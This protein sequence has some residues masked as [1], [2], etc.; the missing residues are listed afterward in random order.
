MMKFTN[1]R[2]TRRGEKK[3]RTIVLTL[4]LFASAALSP[5]TAGAA[6]TSAAAT[7]LAAL[8]GEKV[9]EPAVTTPNIAEHSTAAGPVY[10]GASSSGLNQPT[11][12]RSGPSVLGQFTSDPPSS[13]CG[14]ERSPDV[15]ERTITAVRNVRTGPDLDCPV[16]DQQLTNVVFTSSTYVVRDGYRWTHNGHGWL[17]YA[18]SDGS[19]SI[20]AIPQT[21]TPTAFTSDPPSSQ[22]GRERSPDV[23]ERTITAVR[24]VRTGPDLDCPVVDQQLTNVVFTSS[25]YVVRD[26]YRWTHNGHGWLAY[27]DSDGSN[28]ILA[29][30]QTTTPTDFEPFYHNNST[31]P[32]STSAP[33]PGLPQRGELDLVPHTDGGNVTLRDG[34][35]VVHNRPDPNEELAELEFLREAADFNLGLEFLGCVFDPRISDAEGLL[36]YLRTSYQV[37]R[38]SPSRARGYVIPSSV[39]VPICF[40]KTFL[41]LPVPPGP[42]RE[43]RGCQP[44]QGIYQTCDDSVQRF[45][46]SPAGEGV[47]ESIN[48]PACIEECRYACIH[49]AVPNYKNLTIPGKQQI[50]D[51]YCTF[52]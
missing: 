1:N 20:L 4:L 2:A 33:R 13:Q 5:A 28:S 49:L 19:N 8:V 34:Y 6:E 10:V 3:S 24:N 17:A 31:I 41:A 46:Q 18:D 44:T 26:G 36:S 40:A 14:R 30:P 23:R 22:C 48:H 51:E 52:G 11:S 45:Y 43:V 35:I 42:T 32:E 21:T 25:T 12:F 38:E 27:A 50:F 16:V 15:R 29:I 39:D 9:A 7:T 37:F 47:L